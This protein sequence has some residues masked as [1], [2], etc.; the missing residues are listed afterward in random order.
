MPAAEGGGR[1]PARERG[2]REYAD[3][4]IV[5][6][7]YKLGESDKILRIMTREHGKRSAVARGVRKTGSRFGGRL[8][9]LTCASLLMH[10][11]RNMDTV[12]QVE[13]LTSFRGIREDLDLFVNGSA[14]AELVDNIAVEQEPHPE[15]FDLLW[16][17]LR[18]MLEHPE[19]A[20]FVRAFFEFE[21]MSASG[22]E[23][24]LSR[25]A[26][27]GGEVGVGQTSFSLHLGGYVCERCRSARGREVGKLIR[28]SPATAGVLSWMATHEL[29]DWPCE[30]RAEMREALALMDRVLE[31]WTER[32]F[33]SHRVMREMPAEPGRGRPPGGAR[34]DGGAARRQ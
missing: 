15:L 9:P 27:C 22:F 19:R 20:A 3:R 12:K 18:L 21:V 2:A 25:C 14:M 1:G 8:E 30:E 23:L 10:R 17:A 34:G 4:G 7:S 33:R 5:L 26:A 13:I 16:L 29:G 28:V 31:H 24:M 11:G 32:E 6:R